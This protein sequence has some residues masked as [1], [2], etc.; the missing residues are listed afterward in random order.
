MY[1]ISVL[2]RHT[3]GYVHYSLVVYYSVQI[4]LYITPSFFV[5]LFGML[6]NEIN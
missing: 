5:K 3:Y 6:L 4:N 1:T 2:T